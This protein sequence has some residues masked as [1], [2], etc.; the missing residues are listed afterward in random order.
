MFSSEKYSLVCNVNEIYRPK[1]KINNELWQEYLNL[2]TYDKWH[3]NTLLRHRDIKHFEQICEYCLEI[4]KKKLKIL[5]FGAGHGGISILFNILGHDVTNYDPIRMLPIMKNN[6]N[7]VTS[8]DTLDETFDLVYNSHSFSAVNNLEEELIKLAKITDENTFF[9]IE[10][11]IKTKFNNSIP[12]FKP[13]RINYFIDEKFFENIFYN[14]DKVIYLIQKTNENGLIDRIEV[15]NH[16]NAD[17]IQILTKSKLKP[18][19]K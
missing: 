12:K 10:E 15:D 3:L 8:L 17:L 1:N 11:S 2:V 6:W 14:V 18:N 13:P 5:N 4:Y 9:F 19:I 7:C 16:K